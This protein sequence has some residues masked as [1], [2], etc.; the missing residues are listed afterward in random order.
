[1]GFIWEPKDLIFFLFFFPILCLGVEK[2]LELG[3]ADWTKHE[4]LESQVQEERC[5]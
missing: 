2:S 3:K 4:E 1:M 5:K